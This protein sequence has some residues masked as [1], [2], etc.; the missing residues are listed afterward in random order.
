MSGE[1]N[2]RSLLANM[3]PVLDP[4]RYVFATTTE[5]KELEQLEAIMRFKEDEGETFIL[6]EADATAVNVEKS[7]AYAR[8]TLNV[9]SALDAVGFLATA[10]TALAQEGIS[11]NAVAAFFHDHIFV[12]YDRADD[13]V[14]VLK[15]LSKASMEPPND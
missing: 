10:C 9:H 1:R 12:P 5:L 13:A 2:L 7:D 14:A 4:Q 8:V 11:T 3:S 15:A 6:H